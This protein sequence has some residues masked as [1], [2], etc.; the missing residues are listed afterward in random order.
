M[1]QHSLIQFA[2][3]TIEAGALNAA[4][5]L[6]PE[7]SRVVLKL[8][9]ED[10]F[11]SNVTRRTMRKMT[12]EGKVLDT[13]N[14]S[15]RRVAQ[16]TDPAAGDKVGLDTFNYKLTAQECDLFADVAYSFL[17]D[18]KD[19]PG[20]VGEI[21]SSLMTKIKGELV[22]LA[23]NGQGT[24]FAG[25]DA[26]FLQLNEGWIKLAADSAASKKVTIDPA[27]DGW[28]T[29]LAKIIAPQ[30]KR[31]RNG[32]VLIMGMADHDS[33]AIEIGKHVTGSDHIVNNKASGFIRYP[34]LSNQAVP[35]GTVVFTNP[36]NLILGVNTDITKTREPNGRKRVVEFTYSMNMDF[37]IAAQQ[38]VV[39]AT[40]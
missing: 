15:M 2:K 38:A 12:A 27:T 24:G 22:D 28:V 1:P 4:G 9:F 8:I 3:S 34:V 17:W 30:E 31:F 16:G 29:T 35:D 5:A 21:E 39:L 25:A 19:N 40:T 6:T 26:D 37:Q 32:A 14:R 33:Y 11:F 10:P 18:N 20:L 36:K 13:P 23:F 7:Q